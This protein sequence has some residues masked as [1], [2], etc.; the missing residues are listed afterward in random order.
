MTHTEVLESVLH[1]GVVLVLLLRSVTESY[2]K[3]H[4]QTELNAPSCEYPLILKPLKGWG[5]QKYWIMNQKNRC[6]GFKKHDP[7]AIH[8]KYPFKE[9]A[10][11]LELSPLLLWSAFLNPPVSHLTSRGAERLKQR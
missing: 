3:R 2:Q 5:V 8:S 1:I 11:D 6:Q 4:T 9:H 10:C 7:T